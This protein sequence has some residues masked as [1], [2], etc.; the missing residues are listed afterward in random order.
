MEIRAYKDMQSLHTFGVPWQALVY[1]A[2]DSAE[3]AH[4]ALEYAHEQSLAV[5]VLGGGSNILPTSNWEGLVIHNAIATREVIDVVDEGVVLRVGAGEVWHDLVT[6]TVSH[7]YYGFENLALIPGTVGGAVVQNIGAY[8]VDIARFV[9]SVEVINTKTLE[10]RTLSREECCFAYR[11]SLFKQERGS[12]LV[13]HV[14]CVLPTTYKPVLS[15]RVLNEALAESRTPSAE[16]VMDAVITIR[17]SKLPNPQEVGTAGSFFANP[18]VDDATVARLHAE[19]PDMPVFHNYDS[20]EH[21]IPAG[22]LIEHAGIA[23][24]LKEQ[25]LYPKHHLVVVNNTKNT[26][27]TSG[28]DIESCTR[29]IQEQVHQVFGISLESEV[30]VL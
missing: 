16:E 25:F 13:T 11:N 20:S 30:V 27:K 14:T 26:P 2:V 24:E 21:T 4:K 3:D 22:W 1:C 9:Q 15:Y 28:Q 5:F 19:Y 17:E 29:L 8:D 12:W 23:P 10:Q 18:R 7:G 6:W